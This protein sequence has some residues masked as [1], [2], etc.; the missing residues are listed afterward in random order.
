VTDLPASPNHPYRIFDKLRQVLQAEIV[1]HKRLGAA[2]QLAREL[3][4]AGPPGKRNNTPSRRG[5][6]PGAFL[7]PEK[8]VDEVTKPKRR[9]GRRTLEEKRRALA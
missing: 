2:L 5:Q 3:Q 8:I 1:D 9:V 7:M 4:A 6:V